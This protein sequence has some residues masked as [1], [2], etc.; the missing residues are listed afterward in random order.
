MAELR[1]LHF[2]S[3]YMGKPMVA[4]TKATGDLTINENNL[5]YEIQLGNGTFYY[6][7][8][9]GVW[10]YEDI[11]AINAENYMG[12]GPML[13]LTDKEG[14]Q[15]S[16]TGMFDADEIADLINGQIRKLYSSSSTVYKD[17]TAVTEPSVTE[18]KPR[19]QDVKENNSTPSGKRICRYCGYNLASDDLFCPEC[20][21]IEWIKE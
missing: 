13:T 19:M 17:R 7:G 15:Y 20:G 1:K 2:V 18:Q 16:F 14:K 9:I 11:Q 10:E 21:A 3:Y 12:M 8:P 4:V 6:W 5:V